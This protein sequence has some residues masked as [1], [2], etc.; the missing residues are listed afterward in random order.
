MWSATSRS[1]PQFAPARR[2]QSRQRFMLERLEG[3]SLLS[4]VH[5]TVNTLA[6]DPGGS[7]AG[8]TT[9]RDAITAADAGATAN[10]YVIKFAVDGTIALTAPLPALTGNI[11]I[12]GPGASN[13][14]IESLVHTTPN[15]YIFVVG[16]NAEYGNGV[17][18]GVAF[19]GITITGGQTIAES[20]IF[21]LG[22]LTMKDCVVT[23]MLNAVISDTTF[24]ASNCVF[25]NNG[26]VYPYGADAGAI[27]TSDNS[28][29]TLTND[30]FS[31][32]SN[33]SA[34]AIDNNG[35][36]DI[37]GCIFSGNSATEGFGGAIVNSD[38]VLN[39]TNTVFIDNSAT[40]QPG[41]PYR[42][43]AGGAI[44]SFSG[45]P[46]VSYNSSMSC[47]DDVFIQ[48]TATYGS[49]IAS[50]SNYFGLPGY[51]DGTTYETTEHCI[52]I[53]NAGSA[54]VYGSGTNTHDI[55]FGNS[56]G[57]IQS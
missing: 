18:P 33:T 17:F 7:V 13:L 5:L 6:D 31:G 38:G 47:V 41:Y 26:P 23:N 49:A 1:L 44:A 19:S 20:A 55:F 14:T 25:S 48:N 57:N 3:R 45:P 56:D 4:T 10:K 15:P 2:H 35:V 51:T 8:Q 11:N 12:K 50:I 28:L 36:L 40:S 53:D 54:A 34:G 32:N 29:T 46:F 39:V 16:S 52:F 37:T 43:G 24:T 22:T 21:N 9:L 42:G 30:V 27:V